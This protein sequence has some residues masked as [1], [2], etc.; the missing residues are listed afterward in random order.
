[1][2]NFKRK[3]DWINGLNTGLIGRNETVTLWVLPHGALC[4][5]GKHDTVPFLR[6]GVYNALGAP[7]AEMLLDSGVDGRIIV[8]NESSS[9]KECPTG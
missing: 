6:N 3:T 5:V 9:P 4:E 7:I 2:F 8:C 1:M